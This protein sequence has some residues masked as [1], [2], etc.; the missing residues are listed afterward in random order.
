MTLRTWKRIYYPKQA[1]RVPEGEALD[2]SFRKW[3]GLRPEV[4]A[5]HGVKTS[6]ADR[7]LYDATDDE[8]E[9]PIDDTT[10]ALCV[11]HAHRDCESCPLFIVRKK[12]CDECRPGETLSPYH[13]WVTNSNPEPMIKWLKEAAL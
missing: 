11:H 12:R 6:E 4:L 5:A 2:H 3:E 9:L 1:C 13:S 7:G 8:V 10:C